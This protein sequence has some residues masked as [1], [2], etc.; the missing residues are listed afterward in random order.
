M[1]D[2]SIKG[3]RALKILLRDRTSLTVIEKSALLQFFVIRTSTLIAL[4]TFA[5]PTGFFLDQ[6]NATIATLPDAYHVMAFVLVAATSFGI[7]FGLAF[8][9]VK[10]STLLLPK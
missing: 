5:I 8:A 4:L 1:F 10:F 6:N 7:C 3:V 2:L 9:V